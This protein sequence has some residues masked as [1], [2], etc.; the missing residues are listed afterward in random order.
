MAIEQLAGRLFVKWKAVQGN[1]ALWLL[2]LYFRL[3]HFASVEEVEDVEEID[4]VLRVAPAA[5]EL[6]CLAQ[7]LVAAAVG[8]LLQW[9]YSAVDLLL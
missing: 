7:L 3:D 8:Y 6:H 9:K 5:V 2:G 1:D 4:I